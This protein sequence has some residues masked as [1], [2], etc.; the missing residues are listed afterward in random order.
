[1]N[2]Q[3][4]HTWINKAKPN[5]SIIYYTGHLA[6]DREHIMDISNNEKVKEMA[7]IFRIAAQQKKID[8][9]QNKIKK[10]DQ[11][12]APIYEYIARKLKNERSTV[13]NI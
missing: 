9:F 4:A 3:E 5:N 13:K 7:D 8:L 2:K 10:G 12:K 11:S 6:E 1:M